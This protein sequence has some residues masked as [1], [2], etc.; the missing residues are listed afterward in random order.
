M[1]CRII[2]P[3][4]MYLHHAVGVLTAERRGCASFV[5][6]DEGTSDEF[7]GGRDPVDDA[8]SDDGGTAGCVT[9]GRGPVNGVRIQDRVVDFV[10]RRLGP[11]MSNAVD[12]KNRR[13]PLKPVLVEAKEKIAP[14]VMIRQ[15]RR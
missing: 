14:Y 6:D 1:N 4:F 13:V 8:R 7:D 3:L 15:L 10:K 5:S 2:Y 9:G 11:N 12:G